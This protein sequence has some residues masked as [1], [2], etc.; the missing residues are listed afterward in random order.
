[1]H[2]CCHLVLPDFFMNSHFKKLFFVLQLERTPRPFPRLVIKREVKDID[3]FRVE[4]FE[5]QDYN[6]YPTLKMEM[7]V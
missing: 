5:L 2:C 1:M 3:D 4:D 6:P 7:A